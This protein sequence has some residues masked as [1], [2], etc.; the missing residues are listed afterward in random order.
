MVMS[1]I[2]PFPGSPDLGRLVRDRL[3]TVNQQFPALVPDTLDDFRIVAD[4]LSTIARV[5]QTTINRLAAQSETYNAVEA[6]KDTERALDWAECMNLTKNVTSTTHR[7]SPSCG[8]GRPSTFST[9]PSLPRARPACYRSARSVYIGC[10][11]DT[12]Q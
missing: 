11:E 1:G 7:S 3:K 6:F 9:H 8:Q 12:V 5:C 2:Y 10:L 4:E